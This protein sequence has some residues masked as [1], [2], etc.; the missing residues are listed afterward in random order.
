[1]ALPSVK[2]PRFTDSTPVTTT[3]DIERMRE[4]LLAFAMQFGAYELDRTVKY[5]KIK[6]KIKQ[7]EMQ[8]ENL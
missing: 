2:L 6:S 5:V 8:L 7:L 4:N 3:A 1:M